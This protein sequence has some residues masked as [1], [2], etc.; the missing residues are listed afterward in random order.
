MVGKREIAEIVEEGEDTQNPNVRREA[1]R[2][3]SRYFHH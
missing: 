3:H 2:L 1:Q